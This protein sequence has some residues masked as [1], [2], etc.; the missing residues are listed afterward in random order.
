[1]LLEHLVALLLGGSV[2]AGELI[3]RYKDS[4]ARAVSCL[5]GLAYISLNAVASVSALALLKLFD[6]D[7]GAEGTERDWLQVLVAGFGA[8][9]VL[10]SSLFIARVGDQDVG[11]GPSGVLTQFLDAADRAVDRSRATARTKQASELVQGLDYA[12][13]RAALPLYC[14]WLL[15]NPDRAAATALA[16]QVKQLDQEEIPEAIKTA[17]LAIALMNLVGPGVLKSAINTLEH[18]LGASGQGGPHPPPPPA[19][20]A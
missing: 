7:L 13:A 10:R 16:N 3:S 4:P 8:M 11:V 14:L 9:V 1:M 20:A 19:A 5:G 17:S 6:V 15:Q 18:D 12:K 2:G